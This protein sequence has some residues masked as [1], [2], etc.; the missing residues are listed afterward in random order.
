[1]GILQRWR[2]SLGRR[3]ILGTLLHLPV[4]ALRPWRHALLTRLSA[5]RGP[6]LVAART[7]CVLNL[8]SGP[9]PLP[10]CV[11]VDLYFPA[12]LCLDLTR[13]MPL[14]GACA[15]AVISEH[16]LEHLPREAAER[17]LHECARILR[18]GGWLRVS[19][20]DLEWMVRRYLADLDSSSA[21]AAADGLNERVRAHDHLH[22]YDEALLTGLFAR[23][24][25]VEVWRARPGESRCEL[26]S[27]LEGRL[28]ALG[29]EDAAQHLIIEGR[30]PPE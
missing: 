21:A 11:N 14:P 24:G 25:F 30:I 8:G 19:T 3:G 18:P 5:R 16:L 17:L 23:A 4:A 10:E 15:D 2:R 28:A 29:P 6:R 9:E 7:P 12:D 13:P 1:M 20:P 27:G 22:I 26:L